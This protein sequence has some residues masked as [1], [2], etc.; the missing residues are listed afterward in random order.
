MIWFKDYSCGL[1]VCHVDYCHVDL[2]SISCF[3]SWPKR[4][5]LKKIF[6]GLAGRT[7]D[8][9]KYLG[10]L[11]IYLSLPRTVLSCGLA[12][13]WIASYI[14]G[15]DVNAFSVSFYTS[16]QLFHSMLASRTCV[17]P[18]KVH[19]N[20][21]RLSSSLP[22]LFLASPLSRPCVAVSANTSAGF[23]PTS[24]NL[25]MSPKGCNF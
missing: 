15:S 12:S 8:S 3:G 22:R 17:D 24:I 5:I 25:K 6:F 4:E 2:L 7:N 19:S 21:R 16:D 18:T 20:Q 11:F 1:S 9:P 10:V 14:V 23:D 13:I